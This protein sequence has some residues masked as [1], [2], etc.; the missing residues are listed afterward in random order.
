VGLREQN[1]RVMALSC[2]DVNVELV[3]QMLIEN[4]VDD[5][6]YGSDTAA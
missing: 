4:D 2:D 1:A 3:G 6:S 5:R